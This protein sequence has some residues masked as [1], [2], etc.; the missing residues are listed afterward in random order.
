MSNAAKQ[1]A[2]LALN[3]YS[4]VT[5]QLSESLQ[6]RGDLQAALSSGR[7]QAYEQAT[8]EG[9]NVTNARHAADLAGEHLTQEI[10]KL[11][12]TIDADLIELRY[13]DQLL[14]YYQHYGSDEEE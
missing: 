6:E 8:A 2:Q 11:S 10:A 3:R 4:V 9:A 7:V 5:R 12:G 13:L 14:A 1:G